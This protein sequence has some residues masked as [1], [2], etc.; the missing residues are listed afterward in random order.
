MSRTE[1]SIWIHFQESFKSIYTTEYIKEETTQYNKEETT[2]YNKEETT[3]YIKEETTEYINEETT[4]YINEET[5]EYIKEK[6]TQYNKGETTQ[7]IKE[8]T[9]SILITTELETRKIQR[10]NINDFLNIINETKYETKEE[11]I[12]YYDS[13]LDNIENIFTNNYN[14]SKLDGGKEEI[15][16]TEKMTITLTTSENQ[17][18]NLDN[19]TIIDLGDCEN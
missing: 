15:I 2:Q 17:K 14:T 7:Y 12:E 4:E 18:N 5:S 19:M 16:K 1:W 3:Q 8:E 6:I 11:E 9:T 10:D 13:I